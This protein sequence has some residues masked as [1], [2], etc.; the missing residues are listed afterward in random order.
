[1]IKYLRKEG[2][3]LPVAIWTTADHPY[4]KACPLDLTE[5]SHNASTTCAAAICNRINCKDTTYP[6]AIQILF[7]AGFLQRIVTED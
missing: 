7:E 4:V 5:E 2:V 1:M 3:E 6:E